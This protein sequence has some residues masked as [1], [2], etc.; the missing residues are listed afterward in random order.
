MEKRNVVVIGAGNGGLSAAVALAQ[1]GLKP[2]V[3]ER[4]RLPG[5]CATSFV[6]GQ[7]EFDASIHC[8]FYE[9]QGYKNIWENYMGIDPNLEVVKSGVAY[10]H[11]G[12]DG[13]PVF[14]KYPHGDKEFTE[15]FKKQY[16]ED[17]AKIDELMEIARQF[18]GAVSILNSGGAVLEKS[19][20]RF[21]AIKTKIKML[22]LLLKA[23]KVCPD[24]LK[25]AKMTTPEFFDAYDMPMSVRRY[26]G[27]LWW[28]LGDEL[29]KLPIPRLLGS[30]YFPIDVPCYY[31]VNA[32]HEYLMAMEKKLRDMGGEIRYNE[33]VTEIVM[34]DGKVAGVKT[35]NGT[36]IETEHVISNAGAGTVFKKMIKDDSPVRKELLEEIEN[37]AFNG[38]FATVY[39]GLN[40]S[41]EELG[42][43]NHHIYFTDVDDGH[44]T[45]EASKTF[46]GPYTFGSLCP[47][48]TI[49][50]F[51]PE[52]TCVFT[53]TVGIRP[54]ALEG[55][56]QEEYAKA[57]MQFASDLIDRASFHLGFDLRDYIEEIE[58]M[59]PVTLARYANVEGGALGY[60]V[61][62][63][64]KDNQKAMLQKAV[65]NYKGLTFIGQYS[66]NGIGYSNSVDGYKHGWH[67]SLI[68]KGGK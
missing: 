4:H 2:L 43:T 46:G 59:T 34:K 56:G 5:G 25:L 55:M 58:V 47:N 1:N 15:E 63:H 6:R 49:P 65:K 23:K 61:G 54:E 18:R 29:N 64:D 11:I 9:F 68:I 36:E 17:A 12:E 27:S 40:A 28:Y 26:I 21:S 38:S 60:S 44:A 39:L 51:S 13:K 22:G 24:F 52:G 45:W 57:K 16:P 37:I 14:I 10:S 7:F 41:C 50:D 62:S 8:L 53:L 31:P 42:I 48:V 30:F 3:L 20:S 66:A 19:V 33:E 32:C 35:A 67:E